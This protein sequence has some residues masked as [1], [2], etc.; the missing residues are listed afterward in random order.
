MADEDEA[1]ESAVAGD[2]FVESDGD[3][4][5]RVDTESAPLAALLEGRAELTGE[6]AAK[7][8]KME[9]LYECQGAHFSIGDCVEVFHQFCCMA[10]SRLE[11]ILRSQEQTSQPILRPHDVIV[12]IKASA[13]TIVAGQ[14]P[15]D[16]V[17]CK[18]KSC[19]EEAFGTSG[20]RKSA[21][22]SD[23]QFFSHSCSRPN[24][25]VL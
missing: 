16:R 11:D 20:E 17:L 7:L 6:R 14:R 10:V 9:K 13:E 1:L 5:C 18:L 22:V 4:L 25:L 8:Q 12:R 21:C 23:W 3:V 24:S 15:A 2:D 19:N